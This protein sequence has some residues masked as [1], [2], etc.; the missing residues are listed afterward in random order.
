MT[1]CRT[2]ALLPFGKG[3]PRI[4]GV[5]MTLLAPGPCSGLLSAQAQPASNQTQFVELKLEDYL[6]SVLRQNESVQAQ[7]LE[8]EVN[9][10]K[11]K[12]E[13]GIFEPELVTSNHLATSA[14]P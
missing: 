1:V 14:A 13:K 11:A 12:G 4:I 9:R 7:M 3:L 5:I 6:Q 10:R 2:V 8:A